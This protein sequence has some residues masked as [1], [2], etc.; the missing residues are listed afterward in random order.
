MAEIERFTPEDRRGIETFVTLE[1]EAYAKGDLGRA[2]T[3]RV[4]GGPY[5]R[6][7]S[8]VYPG[9][10]VPNFYDPMISKLSVWAPTRQEA[11]E[12]AKRALDEYVVKGI[13]TNVRYLHALLSHPEFTGGDYDTGFL[14][15]QHE[16]R[17]QTCAGRARTRR[18]AGSRNGGHGSVLPMSHAACRSAV[19]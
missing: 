18:G 5:L 16:A 11:I 19:Y 8:G 2:V 14:T 17:A 6:D 12:R 1:V 7:D 13:T 4:P 3:L 9:Y 15:R 10:T